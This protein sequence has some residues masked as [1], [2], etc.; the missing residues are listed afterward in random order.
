MFGLREPEGG[1]M[2]ERFGESD[3]GFT[4]VELLIVIV[5]LG[6]LAAVVVFSVGGVTDNGETAVCETDERTLLTAVESYYTQW[7]SYDMPS[8]GSPVDDYEQTLIN[9]GFLRQP[10]EYWDVTNAGDVV[11]EAG[12]PS[13]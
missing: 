5:I 3:E 7:G 8:S 9:A 12:I 11:L 13:C 6:I 10:S 2:N 4:L 1:I